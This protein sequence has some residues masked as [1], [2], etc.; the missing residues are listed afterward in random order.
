MINWLQKLSDWFIGLLKPLYDAFI[1]LMHDL[2]MWVVDLVLGALGALISSIP[3]PAF[4]SNNSIGSLVNQLPPFSLYIA[5]QLGIHDAM[6][7]LL[8]GVLF[9]LARKFFTLGQW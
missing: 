3:A 8:S 1:A 6:V 7:I 9:R 5:G 2:F 4:L